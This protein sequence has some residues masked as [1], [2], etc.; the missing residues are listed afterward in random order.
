M[1]RAQSIL[2]ARRAG[3]T[4]AIAALLALGACSSSSGRP[5]GDRPFKPIAEPGNVAASDIAFARAV[6]DEGGPA[7]FRRFAAD[8]A[9][10]QL[11][12]GPVPVP[13]WLG[14]QQDPA[15]AVDWEPR[16]VWSSC[17]GSVAVSF[18]RTRSANDLV[19]SYVTAWQRQRDGSYRWTYHTSALDDPQ[20]LPRAREA[21]P[22]G[23][24]VIVVPGFNAIEGKAADCP[25][26]A[27]PPSS[28]G[29]ATGDDIPQNA[30]VSEDRTLQWRWEQSADAGG[31][32]IVDYLREGEWQQALA[33][34][35][36]A[37]PAP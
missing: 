16:A 34:A 23:D 8:G 4:L 25:G 28:P 29:P 13:D 18:G 14:R 11:L 35:I 15:D 6:R 21:V 24:N 20:P 26:R 32:V 2:P 3:T 37:S 17:D 1:R 31:R 10:V 19:G 36:P 7:A 33:F 12:G 22:E 30:T 27:A 5:G 9:I